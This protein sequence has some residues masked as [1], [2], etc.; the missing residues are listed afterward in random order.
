MSFGRVLLSTEGSHNH[1]SSSDRPELDNRLIEE[2]LPYGISFASFFF[3]VGWCLLFH[4]LGCATEFSIIKPT[5]MLINRGAQE[6]CAKLDLW[7]LAHCSWFG[8]TRLNFICA[9]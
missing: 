7:Q 8:L 5:L 6:N 9:K 2:V 1:T 4:L 3:D